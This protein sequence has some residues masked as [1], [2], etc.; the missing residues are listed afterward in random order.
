M[1]QHESFAH[2]TP[3][4]LPGC[5][6]IGIQSGTRSHLD[7]GHQEVFQPVLGEDGEYYMVC[8]WEGC[9][10]EFPVQWIE[11]RGVWKVDRVLAHA[12]CIVPGCGWISVNINGP[13][14]KHLLDAHNIPTAVTGG[15]DLIPCPHSSHCR[16]L[17]AT[18]NY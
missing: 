3:C 18:H 4:P 16:K 11:G 15:P 6:Y 5:S 10:A 9:E 17:R 14:W 2:V 13:A 12:K 8:P 1:V 7:R